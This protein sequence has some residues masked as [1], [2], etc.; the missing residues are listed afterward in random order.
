MSSG[1]AIGGALGGPLGLTCVGLSHWTSSL[2]VRE[3]VALSEEETAE[4]VRR[5]R[6]ARAE[7]AL[8]LSTCNRTEF[9]T[10]GARPDASRRAVREVVLA[11]KG[12]DLERLDGALVT[13]CEP[14]AVR[15]LFRVASGLESMVLGEQEILGQVRRAAEIAS[16]AG[17]AG[18]VMGKM[19]ES[20]LAA[21]KRARTETAIGAGAV[22]IGSAGVE[23]ARKVFGSLAGRRVLVVGAGEAARL[24]AEHLAGAGVREFVVANRG[25]ERGERLAGAVG[26][27][28]IGI[29]RIGEALAGVDLVV[30]ATSSPAPLVRPPEVREALR[31]RSGR[32]IVFLDLAV[33]RDVDPDVNALPNVFVH[34]LDALRAI[35]EANLDRRRRE[36]PRV[37][38]IVEEGVERF[39]GWHRSLAAT[40]TLVAFRERVEG[41]RTAEVARHRHAF[42]EEDLPAVEALTR[43]IVRKILHAPTARLREEPNGIL[44]AARVDALRHLFDLEGARPEGDGDGDASRRGEDAPGDAEEAD[45]TRDPR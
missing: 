32:R 4:A 27:R 17:G 40:P 38:A 11:L 45:A 42:R 36:V 22:S 30:T 44:G 2:D 25:A 1:S 9:Y 23:L 34:D 24:A 5:L 37:E 26:G 13:R 29:D 15:H 16:R 21:A 19:A 31:R 3:A 7:E 35:I 39:L 43:A 28:A 18:V 10:R 33:P 20:A 6:T 8:V 14:D 41:I 12:V